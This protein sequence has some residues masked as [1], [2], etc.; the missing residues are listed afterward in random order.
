MFKEENDE[1]T[2]Y[3]DLT[4]NLSDMSD[5][6]E[7]VEINVKRLMISLAKDLMGF[8]EIDEISEA[9]GLTMEEVEHI[10]AKM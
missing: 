1:E 2:E 8:K 4:E 3:F 5:L 10:L 6:P 9:T 7:S